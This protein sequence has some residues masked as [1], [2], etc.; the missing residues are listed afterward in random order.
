MHHPVR[1]LLHNKICNGR[2]FTVVLFT[3]ITFST[4]IRKTYQLNPGSLWI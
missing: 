1:S 3:P 4:L 2:S